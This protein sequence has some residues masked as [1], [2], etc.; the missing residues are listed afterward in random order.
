MRASSACGVQSENSN[1]R[2]LPH[3]FGFRADFFVPSSVGIGKALDKPVRRDVVIA[4]HCEAWAWKRIDEGPG[5]SKLGMSRPLREVAADGDE[6][7]WVLMKLLLQGI[8][9][10]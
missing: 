10:L 9:D 7:R 8:G 2:S 4:G 3:R 5:C 1:V 6:I